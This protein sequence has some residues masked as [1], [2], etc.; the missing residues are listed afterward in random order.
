[1]NNTGTQARALRSQAKLSRQRLGLAALALAGGALLALNPQPAHAATPA[2]PVRVR[3]FLLKHTPE[4]SS[5]TAQLI[6][7]G[8]EVRRDPGKAVPL[9]LAARTVEV[10]GKHTCSVRLGDVNY[11]VVL[12]HSA[13]ALPPANDFE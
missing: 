7:N 3:L 9:V 8:H 4:G 12:H 11:H 10:T 6:G 5:S 2:A 13:E 1:M